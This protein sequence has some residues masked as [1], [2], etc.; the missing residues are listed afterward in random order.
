VSGALALVDS[1]VTRLALGYGGDLRPGDRILGVPGRTASLNLE[2]R[3]REW[4]GSVGLERAWDWINYDRLALARDLAARD[5]VPASE[6]Y[7]WRLRR[8][9]IAYDGS[10]EL[11]ATL[12]RQLRPGVWVTAAGENLLGRQVGEPDNVGIRAGRTLTM[13]IRAS[14]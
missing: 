3:S 1:R 8:Y 11:R 10:T 6:L 12:W 2:W 13:G 9:W 14:F 7:G 4:T 5:S